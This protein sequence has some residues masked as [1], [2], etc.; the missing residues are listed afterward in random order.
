MFRMMQE[1]AKNLKPSLEKKKKT[2]MKEN[3]R[4]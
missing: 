2:R 3:E 1:K 4:I